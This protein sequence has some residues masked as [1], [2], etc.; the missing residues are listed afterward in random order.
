MG[1]REKYL[2]FFEQYMRLLQ[3]HNSLPGKTVFFLLMLLLSP[4]T[5]SRPYLAWIASI[6]GKSRSIMEAYKKTTGNYWSFVF[7]ASVMSSLFALSYYVDYFFQQDSLIYITAV[8]SLYF[9]IVFINIYKN[10]YQRRPKTE[11]K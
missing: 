11:Q 5:L 4:Y 10:F 1:F 8:L 3:S 6:I 2:E 9:C 7:C